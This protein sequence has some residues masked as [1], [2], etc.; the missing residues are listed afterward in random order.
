MWKEGEIFE[1]EQLCV[2]D[3]AKEEYWIERRDVGL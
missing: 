1:H 2:P 3:G